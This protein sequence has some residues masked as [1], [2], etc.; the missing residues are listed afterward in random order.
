MGPRGLHGL[1]LLH[2]APCPHGP[3]LTSA[4]GQTYTGLC[5][6]RGESGAD[7]SGGAVAGHQPSLAELGRLSLTKLWDWVGLGGAQSAGLGR[8]VGICL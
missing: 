3:D 8:L 5:A 2:R 6:R 1:H 4:L 7:F